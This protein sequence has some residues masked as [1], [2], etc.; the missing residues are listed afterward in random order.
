MR[1]L[2]GLLPHKKTPPKRGL[3]IAN[4]VLKFDLTS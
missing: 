1:N 3:F 4:T 2:F